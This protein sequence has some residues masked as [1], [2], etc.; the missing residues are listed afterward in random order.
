VLAGDD[1]FAVRAGAG[2]EDV[3]V[4]DPVDQAV[5]GARAGPYLAVLHLFLVDSVVVLLFAV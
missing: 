5:A 1:A 3:G 2:V 4:A